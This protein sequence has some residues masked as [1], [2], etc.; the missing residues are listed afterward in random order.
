MHGKQEKNSHGSPFSLKSIKSFVLISLLILSAVTLSGCAD[1]T[2][3]PSREISSSGIIFGEKSRYDQEPQ[4][5][6]SQS[7]NDSSD[8]DTVF[9]RIKEKVENKEPLTAWELQTYVN[10]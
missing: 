2:G 3:T 4:E 6:T 1:K 9:E 5:N 7:G 8:E 10:H